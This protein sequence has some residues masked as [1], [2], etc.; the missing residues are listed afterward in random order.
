[1][2]KRILALS[3]VL[4]LVGILVTPIAAFAANPATGAIT[5]T[6]TVA[7]ITWAITVPSTATLTISNPRVATSCTAFTVSVATNDNSMT[8]VQIGAVGTDAVA[9][10]KLGRG[11]RGGTADNEVISPA[12]TGTS[13]LLGWTASTSLASSVVGN[14]G[15]KQDLSAEGAFSAADVVITQPII[16]APAPVIAAAY[17]S[18]ITFTATFTIN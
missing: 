3:M 10:G 4:A 5:V 2:K 8:K 12:L 11:D 17:T 16:T 9:P 14:Q 7:T 1:M 13:T 15:A 6:G 18:V